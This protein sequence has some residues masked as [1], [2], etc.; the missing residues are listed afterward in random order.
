MPKR[1]LVMID[2]QNDYFPGGKWPLSGIE[3]AAENAVKLMAAAGGRA[4]WWCMCGMN[5][6]RP[7][8]RSLRPARKAPSCIRR[9]AKQA[10]S[11]WC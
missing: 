5:F 7:T 6:R 1:A 8:P 3:S 2:I 11:L 9:C 10:M 4:T